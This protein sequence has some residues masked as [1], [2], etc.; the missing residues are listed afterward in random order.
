[1]SAVTD[2]PVRG[3]FPSRNSLIGC[4]GFPCI[5]F[6]VIPGQRGSLVPSR[7][8]GRFS[9]D[10]DLE[11]SD[12]AVEGGEG[13]REWP[14]RVAVVQEATEAIHPVISYAEQVDQPAKHLMHVGGAGR[15]GDR[16]ALERGVDSEDLLCEV[17]H[18][19]NLG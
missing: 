17:D 8:R 19:G 10:L 4:H 14:L 7:R 15:V 6:R 3:R 13:P 9:T 11:V 18:D 5:G 2:S 16:S 12:P 1:M